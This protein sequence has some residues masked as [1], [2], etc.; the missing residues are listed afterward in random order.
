MKKSFY[1]ICYLLISCIAY[2]Q[3]DVQQLQQTAKAFMRQGDFANA[4]TVLNRGLQQDPQNLA[5]AKDLAF[6]YYLQKDN[7]KALETIKPVLENDA[8]LSRSGHGG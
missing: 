8:A 7:N 3:Q 6:A 2:A 1:C 5:I 4:I